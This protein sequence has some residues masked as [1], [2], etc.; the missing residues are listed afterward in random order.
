[1]KDSILLIIMHTIGAACSTVL[2]LGLDQMPDASSSIFLYIIIA[3]I[4]SF[5]CF[6]FGA[7]SC[8]SLFGIV[9]YCLL[10]CW[11]KRRVRDEE[12]CTQRVVEEVYIM[13]DICMPSRVDIIS[14]CCVHVSVL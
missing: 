3:Q 5:I 7:E 10:A 9:L 1:M 11:Y 2:Q 8:T 12:Y 14:F 6:F 4:V 13:I